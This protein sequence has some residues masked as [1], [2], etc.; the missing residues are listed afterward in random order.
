MMFASAA[1]V[2]GADG[3]G[4]GI[5]DQDII[6]LTRAF[7]L[8]SEGVECLRGRALRVVI[9]DRDSSFCAFERFMKEDTNGCL[10]DSAS[11]S[12]ECDLHT[13]MLYNVATL[14][15]NVATL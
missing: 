9:A 15:Y 4:W 13:Y 1:A 7:F 2:A 6:G 8:T 11:F 14:L 10:A 12:N 5:D 3:E